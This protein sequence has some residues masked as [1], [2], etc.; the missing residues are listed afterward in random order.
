MFAASGSEGRRI[1]EALDH[2]I[3]GG[4]GYSASQR[5]PSPASASRGVSIC[6]TD[7]CV[8]VWCLAS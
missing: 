6:E 1:I 2:S 3:G 5:V 4:A 7:I 8:N